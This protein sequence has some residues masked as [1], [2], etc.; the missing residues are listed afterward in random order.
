[1][2]AGGYGPGTK[3]TKGTKGG[4]I[5][6]AATHNQ[7]YVASGDNFGNVKMFTRP[8][9]KGAA[10]GEFPGHSEQVTSLAFSADDKHLFT[11]GG[12][13]TGVMQWE[14]VR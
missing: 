8:A 10:V 1:M 2:L 13:D 9:V 7:S 5:P 12:S 3:G 14:I 6:C 4:V 11:A